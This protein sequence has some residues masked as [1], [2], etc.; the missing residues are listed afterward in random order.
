MDICENPAA[1]AGTEG[2]RP[3]LVEPVDRDAGKNRRHFRTKAAG[4]W[5]PAGQRV[6]GD[7]IEVAVD[8]E[9]GASTQIER[10][11][12]EAQLALFRRVGGVQFAAG[13]LKNTEG[14]HSVLPPPGTEA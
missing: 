4:R 1:T 9:T 8:D 13:K 11:F 3:E 6:L 7:A 12:L 10:E 5:R 2:R 14:Q